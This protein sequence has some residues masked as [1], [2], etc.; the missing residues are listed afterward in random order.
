MKSTWCGQTLA[1]T[2]NLDPNLASHL[3][4]KVG[5]FIVNFRWNILNYLHNTFPIIGQLAMQVT[6]PTI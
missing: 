6:I 5:D 2:P 1:S 3:E 4:A